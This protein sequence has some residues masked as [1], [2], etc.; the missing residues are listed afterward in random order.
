MRLPKRFK[1]AGHDFKIIYNKN[2]EIEGTLGVCKFL[3]NEIHIRTEYEGKEISED[4]LFQT[5]C[6][7]C[8]HAVMFVLNKHELNSDEDFIDSTS[9]L[10]WQI[11]K[12]IK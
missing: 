6:H 7:E 12:T 1:I 8:L 3:E 2:I 11:I 10:L 4:Q 9:Q 5:I